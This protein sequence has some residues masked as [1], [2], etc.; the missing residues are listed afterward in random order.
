VIEEITR[1]RL[2]RAKRL[3]A[4][5]DLPALLGDW[6]ERLESNRTEPRPGELGTVFRELEQQVGSS[7]GS[8]KWVL[9]ILIPQILAGGGAAYYFLFF[10]KKH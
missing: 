8:L 1:C 7:G 5:T 6:A 4:E 10:L 3:L 9:L 2:S